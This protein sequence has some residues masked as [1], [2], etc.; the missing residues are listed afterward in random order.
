[1][2]GDFYY[3]SALSETEASVF[4]CDVAGHGV[5]SA[6]ITAVI[7]ALLEELKPLS[8]DPGA[9]LTRLNQELLNILRHADAS[10]LTTACCLVA[11]AATGTLRYANAGHPRPFHVQRSAGEVR[12]LPRATPR[13]QPALGLV[14][15]ATYQNAEVTLQPSDLVMLYTDGLYEVHNAAQEL[16]STEQLE[17][18]VRARLQEP[19][20]ELFDHLLAEV[21]TFAEKQE[22]ED[23]VCLLGVDFIQYLSR[24]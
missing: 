12:P 5:R 16:Y 17:A 8:R 10:I 24:R 6:L 3:V 18:A 15:T 20:P 7:R 2:G 21:R 11:D 4:L 14:E 19:T 1:V 22:F 23:D 13:P 9:L